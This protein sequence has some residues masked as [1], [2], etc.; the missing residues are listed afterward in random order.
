M[1]LATI[2]G[3][4]NAAYAFGWAVG[5]VV[6]GV[7]Y[8]IFDFD[9]FASI[10]CF[11]CAVYTL[12]M[13]AV[14]LTFTQA[15]ACR[16]DAAKSADR[17]CAGGSLQ[18]LYDLCRS[19]L[20]VCRLAHITHPSAHNPHEATQP[21]QVRHHPRVHSLPGL[22]LQRPK[23]DVAAAHSPASPAGRLP[24]KTPCACRDCGYCSVTQ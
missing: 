12:V 20:P 17:S 2:S 21:T 19:P 23:G 5:P 1:L 4:W 15:S 14:A 16:Q 24:S 9:G 22:M 11:T 7:L 18:G 10:V 6:G 8:Q 13:I 3:L